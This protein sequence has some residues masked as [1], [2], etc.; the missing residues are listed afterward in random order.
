MLGSFCACESRESM[1]GRLRRAIS[2]HVL[3]WHLRQNKKNVIQ[4]KN[5]SWKTLKIWRK[6][7]E[8][9]G[10]EIVAVSCQNAPPQAKAICWPSSGS[11]TCKMAVLI[12][13]GFLSAWT[14]YAAVSFWSIFHSSECCHIFLL[15]PQQPT[16]LFIY[17][18]FSKT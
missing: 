11:S 12:S 8:A 7:S 16:T 9:C 14:P 4:K 15:N 13:V 17:Y 5:S 6:R 10:D 18:T 1:L 2:L 3:H